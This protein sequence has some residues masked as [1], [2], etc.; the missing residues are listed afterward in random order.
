MRKRIALRIAYDG[1]SFN[2]FQSLPGKKTVEGRLIAVLAKI[3]AIKDRRRSNFRSSSRTDKGVS[4][5]GNIVSIDTDFSPDRLPRAINSQDEDIWCTGIAIL[6]DDFNVRRARSRT[7]GCYLQYEG[8]KIEVMRKASRQFLGRHDFSRYARMDGRNPEREIKRIEIGK[9]NGFIEL[10]VEGDSFL[11]NQVRR[12]VWVLDQVG[13]SDIDPESIA[14]ERFRIRR[15][16]LV[17]AE[18]LLLLSVD[19]GKRFEPPGI[20]SQFEKEINR[21][22]I[23]SLVKK[24]LFENITDSF[25]GRS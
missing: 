22:L 5:L 2:G 12:M 19:I 1:S 9:V 11:W 6:P 8:Q 25:Q 18:H 4:A 15:V 13:R 10:I 7:Y 17:P 16:G 3:K 21:L 20:H 23:D 24:R 14:P